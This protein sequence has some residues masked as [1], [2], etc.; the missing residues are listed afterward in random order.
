[1]SASF[2]P[3][4][5]VCACSESPQSALNLE[6]CMAQQSDRSLPH[7]CHSRPILAN[8]RTPDFRG[9]AFAFRPFVQSAAFA[10]GGLT[11]CG[12]SVHSLRFHESLLCISALAL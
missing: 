7:H 10:K 3:E 11:Q 12:Q 6:L 4:Q 5:L 8:H 9:A 2:S 1:M